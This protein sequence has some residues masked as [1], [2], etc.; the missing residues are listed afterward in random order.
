VIFERFDRLGHTIAIGAA[1]LAPA[2]TGCN[3]IVGSGDYVIGDAG[4]PSMTPP[5]GDDAAVPIGEG[6]TT[7]GNEAGA[8]DT[9]TGTRTMDAGVDGTSPTGSGRLG[10]PCHS[11]TDCAVGSCNG[12]SCTQA[13]KSSSSCGSNSQNNPNYCVDNGNGL[14]SCLPGCTSAADCAPFANTSCKPVSGSSAQVCQPSTSSQDA[15]SAGGSVG[16]PCT[17]SGATC[18]QNGVGTCNGTWC[19]APCDQ[20]NGASACPTNSLGGENECVEDLTND[21]IC[22]PGCTTNADCT[23]YALTTCQTVTLGNGNDVSACSATSKR[24]GDPCTADS[25]C[26]APA[27]CLTSGGWCDNTCASLTDTSCGTTSTGQTNKCVENTQS[28]FS[29]FP[30]CTT[31]DDC[32]VYSGTYCQ[33]DFQAGTTA[34]FVCAASGGGVGDPCS[35]DSDCTTPGATCPGAWC[36]I[37]CSSATDTATCGTDLAGVQNECV[38]DSDTLDFVCFPGCTTDADCTAYANATC[39]STGVGNQNVCSY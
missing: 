23:P 4:G 25:D 6:G 30:G 11:A 3:L 7:P 17:T 16:D 21:F 2:L 1:L 27:T 8:P 24:I 19:E 31:A 10:D 33:R 28:G 32:T 14:L 9:G 29:C 12:V 22:F 20:S 35:S 39:V 18:G 37:P 38:Q 36:S 34:A 15:S 26:T 13:C 5:T